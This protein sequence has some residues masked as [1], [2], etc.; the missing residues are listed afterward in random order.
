MAAGELINR[1]RPDKPI[2]RTARCSGA[3]RI[4]AHAPVPFGQNSRICMYH[5]DLEMVTAVIKLGICGLGVS[6]PAVREQRTRVVEIATVWR[7][8]ETAYA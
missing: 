5:A 4:I 8:K 2:S 6:Q 7:T 3:K 1:N